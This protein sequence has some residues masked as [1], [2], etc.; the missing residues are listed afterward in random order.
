MINCF[1][2]S[3]REQIIDA[4][5]KS[6]LKLSTMLTKANARIGKLEGELK[7]GSEVHS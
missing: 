5:H 6:I 4:Q 7:K 1:G 2:C 3:E